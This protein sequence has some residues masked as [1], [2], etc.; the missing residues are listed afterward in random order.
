MLCVSGE[1]WG[2]G[3]FSRVF[4][5]EVGI[6]PG[7]RPEKGVFWAGGGHFH[8]APARKGASAGRKWRS[9]DFR[10]GIFSIICHGTRG[11]GEVHPHKITTSPKHS[12]QG[13]CTITPGLGV[14]TA[15]ETLISICRPRSFEQAKS[16]F[17]HPTWLKCGQRPT[18]ILGVF[19]VFGHSPLQRGTQKPGR[20]QGGK[21][22]G[23][24]VWASPVRWTPN[25][26]RTALIFLRRQKTLN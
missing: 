11:F 20:P 5:P 8:R 10:G 14:S 7:F 23:A 25:H 24:A 19:T 12:L 9:C 13:M 21:P 2:S 3:P 26:A 17:S 22:G 15:A 1:K 6:S 18:V 16:S 4:G